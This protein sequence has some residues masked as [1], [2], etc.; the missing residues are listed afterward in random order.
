M[1]YS[2]A[3]KTINK[4]DTIILKKYPH[5]IKFY[6]KNRKNIFLKNEVI[7]Y[8]I[9]ILLTKASFRFIT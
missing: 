8:T 3:L 5:F 1:Y 9:F 7:I 4:L 2:K 6:N